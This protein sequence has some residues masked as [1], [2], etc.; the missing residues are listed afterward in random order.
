M[1]YA[2]KLLSVCL[3]VNSTNF[4]PCFTYNTNVRRALVFNQIVNGP[5]MRERNEEPWW[6]SMSTKVLLLNSDLIGHNLNFPQKC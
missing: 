2:E 5:A 1:L 6:Y 4:K 3:W